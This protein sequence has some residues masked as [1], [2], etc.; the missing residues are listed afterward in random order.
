[1]ASKRFPGAQELLRSCTP[2]P[3]RKRKRFTSIV[4]GVP[5]L[6]DET[7]S[8]WIRR[9][10][11]ECDKYETQIPDVIEIEALEE[12]FR[13]IKK[14]RPTSDLSLLEKYP[15]IKGLKSWRRSDSSSNNLPPTPT[16]AG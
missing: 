9:I 16:G 3:I 2:P 7:Y 4:K 11:D 1:L 10:L 14:S 15:N 8:E 12:L 6:K 13:P 5:R